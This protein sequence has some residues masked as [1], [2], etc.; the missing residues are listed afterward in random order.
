M[1]YILLKPFTERR[2]GSQNPLF[3]STIS[4]QQFWG[5]L[6]IMNPSPKKHPNN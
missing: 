6:V 4:I 2:L 5:S 1:S 3:I